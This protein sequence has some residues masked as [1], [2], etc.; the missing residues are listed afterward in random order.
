LNNCTELAEGIK[1]DIVNGSYGKRLALELGHD[2]VFLN[3][4]MDIRL[5][6]QLVEFPDQRSYTKY[7]LF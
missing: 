1:R 7:T 3:I 6:L 2:R 5:F 4:V